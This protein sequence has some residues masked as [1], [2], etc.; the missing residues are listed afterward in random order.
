[1]TGQWAL[2]LREPM[3]VPF[4]SVYVLAACLWAL[5]SENGDDSE[6][7]HMAV[8]TRTVMRCHLARLHAFDVDVKIC[9]AELGAMFSGVEVSR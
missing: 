2:Q 1:M 9:G 4:P 5:T 8:G 7:R 3:S 6:H